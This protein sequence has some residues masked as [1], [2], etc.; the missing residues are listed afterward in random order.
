MQSQEEIFERPPLT[1]ERPTLE[2]SFTRGPLTLDELATGAPRVGRRP[3]RE[4]EF[5]GV[6]LEREIPSDYGMFN[7][8]MERDVFN[9]F[10]KC[11]N[12]KRSE[13][14]KYLTDRMLE[15]LINV[16]YCRTPPLQR[17]E[18]CCSD[19]LEQQPMTR[20]R[21]LGALEPPYRPNDNLFERRT[22]G[23]PPRTFSSITPLTSRMSPRNVAM[24]DDYSS[25]EFL[26]ANED[27]M[28]VEEDPMEQ[29]QNMEI[30]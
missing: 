19:P 22:T 24:T 18:T 21:R 12:Q 26:D 28:Y 25:D 8:H 1:L 10:D 17:Q 3:P 5:Q 30:E 4:E 2:R 11:S 9:W 13:Y 29:S 20:E 14:I 16:P 15:D 6:K 23:T 27:E 7:E